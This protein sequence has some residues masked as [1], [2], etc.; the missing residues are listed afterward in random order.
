MFGESDQLP[1]LVLDRYGDVVVGQIAT[2]GMEALRPEV[3]AA[4]R[5]VLNPRV[6]Y[7]KNDSGRASWSSC[8]VFAGPAFGAVPAEIDVRE[9]GI[10][11]RAPLA[12]GQKTGWF[13]DQSRKPRPAGPLSRPAARACWMCAATWAPGR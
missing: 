1:G 13:Y 7:W 2:A 9:A 10:D 5:E 8:R 12:H 11:F 4:V 3:E 6:L